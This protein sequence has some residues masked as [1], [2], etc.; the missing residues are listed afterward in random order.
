[1]AKN[2]D[3]ICFSL[4]DE[5]LKIVHTR[6]IDAKAKVLHL[7][8]LNVK[9]VS[10]EELPKLI[11]NAVKKLPLKKSNLALMVPAG[12]VTSKNIEIPSVDE[13]EIYS[14][15]DLQAARHTPFSREEIE[16]GF[17]NI[18]VYNKNFTKVLLTIA[19]RAPLKAQINMFEKA[20]VRIEKVLFAQE[21][22]KKARSINAKTT[23]SNVI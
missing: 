16:I 7:N 10:Q 8:C 1:M 23:S 9:G 21:G 3:T 22:V 5:F 19:N 4:N 13:D 6:G 14:I 17:I 18:G 2:L 11:S 20:G 12:V 15:V